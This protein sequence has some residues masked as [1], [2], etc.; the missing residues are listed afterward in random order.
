MTPEVLAQAF[1]PF[2]TT[3]EV[4]KGTGLGLASVYGL[5]RQFGGYIDIESAPGRGTQVSIYLP[6]GSGDATAVSLAQ[7]QTEAGPIPGLI[8]LAEDES[9]VRKLIASRL[10][11]DGFH[12]LEAADGDEAL[13][14]GTS[15]DQ[16]VDLL[17]CDVV[18]PNRSG[19]GL[20][21]E[22]RKLRP[23]LPVVFISGFLGD[24]PRDFLQEF[25]AAEFLHKPL[26]LERLTETVRRLLREQAS[27]PGAPA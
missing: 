19:T 10:R 8:L 21:R 12:V 11:S 3:K 17:I 9:S 18:M 20:A 14:V 5:V 23:D 15:Q 1:E 27:E 25:E 13:A 6:K 26:R 2:F 24:L 22:L 4:G 7:P 16:S